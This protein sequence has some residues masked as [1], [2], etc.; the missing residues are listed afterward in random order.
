MGKEPIREY[1]LFE[2]AFN[3][4]IPKTFSCLPGNVSHVRLWDS[5][6]GGGEGG[7]WKEEEEE[8]EGGLNVLGGKHLFTFSCWCI[9]SKGSR[10][11]PSGVHN[12]QLLETH[13]SALRMLMHQANSPVCTVQRRDAMDFL[14]ET[15]IFYQG[16]ISSFGFNYSLMSLLMGESKL[17]FQDSWCEG[18][19]CSVCILVL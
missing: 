16:D 7:W 17:V 5:G 13:C 12:A 19:T 8:E 1:I 4:L 15:I 10:H 2:R 14:W 9:V 11:T 18:I 3:S 6:E